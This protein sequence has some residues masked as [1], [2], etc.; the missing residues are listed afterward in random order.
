MNL[1]TLRGELKGRTFFFLTL[2]G[3]GFVIGIW[4]L[5]T[6]GPTP[7]LPPGI[8]PSP[9]RV[10]GAFKDL[11]R[12]NDIVRNTFFSIGLNLAGY[13][14]AIALAIPL[15]FI[16][17]LLPIFRGSFQ[18]QVDAIRYIPLTAL[19]GLFIVWF[20]I[21]IGMKVHFLAFGILIYL[22]PVMIQR[23]DE[24]QD[25]F[26]KTVYTIGA[27][28]WQTFRTVYFPSVI[29][30]LSDDIRVL[31]AISWTYIIVA[32][33][34]SSEGGI[35]SLIWRVGLRQ[36]RVDKVFA[37]LII[38]MVIGVLQ[39]RFLVW[40]DKQLFPHK[41]QLRDQDKSGQ[42]HNQ[43]VVGVIWQYIIGTLFWILC[44]V[45]LLLF[46]NEFFPFL[47]SKPLSYL[48]GGTVWV[49]H[50]VFLLLIGFFV[51]KVLT[52]SRK[53]KIPQKPV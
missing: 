46:A 41:Y 8:L 2:L 1:F 15:G 35:G 40:L 21:G 14:E 9:E 32:E 3:A 34:I 24:V 4:M 38:I 30:R 5:L 10:L 17:G 50:L 33:G 26:L 37:M 31:T 29:S 27:N 20:G 51:I 53:S 23:I 28:G 45:Y 47:G 43:T 36:G 44:A 48:F 39:D 19:T 16:V 13:V 18:F 25:V 12:D 7:V 42:L 52:N 49:V 11:Y 6:S 22:L